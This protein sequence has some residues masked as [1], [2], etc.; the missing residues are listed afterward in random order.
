MTLVD[1]ILHTLT[2][3]SNDFII[4]W[5]KLQ[6]NNIKMTILHI[7]FLIRLPAKE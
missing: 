5:K 1:K 6:N 7:F 2:W 3:Q 4:R